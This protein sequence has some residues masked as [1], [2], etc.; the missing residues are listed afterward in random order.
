MGHY[1]ELSTQQRQSKQQQSFN[2]RLVKHI[3][4][5]AEELGHEFAPCFTDKK[6]RDRIRCFF[7]THLQNA[8]KRLTTMQKHSN[9]EEQKTALGALIVKAQKLNFERPPTIYGNAPKA[10]KPASGPS[11]AE[12]FKVAVNFAIAASMHENETDEASA[13][14]R[15]SVS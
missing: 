4:S 15:R 12:A 7:K 11:D 6:L 2:N 3:R 14:R 1:Y 9:S 10:T 13:K 5:T 8:K